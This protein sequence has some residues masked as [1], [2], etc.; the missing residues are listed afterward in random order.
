MKV[1]ITFREGE[2]DNLFVHTLYKSI[3]QQGIDVQCSTDLFWKDNDTHYDVIHFQWP[4]E[5]VGWNCQDPQV[6][7]RLGKRVEWWRERGSRFIY[8]R[9]NLRPHYVSSLISAAYDIIERAADTVVH[10]GQFSLDEYQSRYPQSRNVLIPHHIYE[11]T[12]REDIGQTEAR[13][14]LGIAPDRFVITAFG[15]FRNREEVGM[16]LRAFVRANIRRKYLLA[17]RLF[18]FY[19]RPWYANWFKCQASRLA[20]HLMPLARLW[21]IRGGSNEEIV[22]DEELPYYVAASDVIVVQRK[23]ILNSGNVPLAFLFH[24]VAIGPDTGNISEFLRTTGNPV[25]DADNT[26]SIV[27]ALEQ[28]RTLSAQGQGERNYQ[29]ARQHLALDT[30]AEMYVDTYRQTAAVQYF[31]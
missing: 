18:P 19:R 6:I 3:Q 11:H 7:E 25:F 27:A 17:P 24:K 20:Y 26:A 5:L 10:M 9:H 8:T 23:Q 2:T 22:S 13:A 29:Y 31:S 4:E 21:G 30:I 16:V 14:Y 28:A 12:Y 1:L 15:K